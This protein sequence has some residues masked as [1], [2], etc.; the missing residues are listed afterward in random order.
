MANP[1]VDD[2]GGMDISEFAPSKAPRVP[3]LV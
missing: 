3:R 1:P 2:G